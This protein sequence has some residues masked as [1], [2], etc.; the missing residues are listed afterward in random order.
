M[1]LINFPT[2]AGVTAY[3][4]CSA[5]KVKSIELWAAAPSSGAPT[6]NSVE[7]VDNTTSSATNRIMVSD[8]TMGTAKPL[9]V[10]TRPP[11]LSTVG[12]WQNGGSQVSFTLNL[13][14]ANTIIDLTVSFSLQDTN[15]TPSI[16]TSTV[17]GTGATNGI[18]CKSLDGGNIILPYTWFVD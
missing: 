7:W 6:T 14:A 13:G 16:T 10:Y 3:R 12:F 2:V 11:K 17:P 15:S 1:D 18:C 8:T 5:F 9:H 4:V